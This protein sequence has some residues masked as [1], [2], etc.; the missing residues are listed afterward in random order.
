MSIS[1]NHFGSKRHVEKAQ[2]GMEEE[3]RRAATKGGCPGL[4][5]SRVW[6]VF[7]R[8]DCGPLQNPCQVFMLENYENL[9][10]LWK[11]GLQE[12]GKHSV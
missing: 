1:S 4:P 5:V 11:Q 10:I 8:W 3:Q 12:L 7:F 9:E 2:V 6:A